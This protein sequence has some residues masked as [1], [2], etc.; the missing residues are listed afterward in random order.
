MKQRPHTPIA[1]ANHISNLVSIVKTQA[2]LPVYPIDVKEVAFE[3]STQMFPNSKI[4]RIEGYDFKGNIEGALAPSPKKDNNWGILYNSTTTPSGRIN[5][6]IAHEFGHFLLH[7]DKF[8]SG[9]QCSSNDLL[10]WDS[11][12]AKIEAEANSF[13][14]N[15]LMPLDDFRKQIKS[16]EVT[17]KCLN[18]LS[19]RYQVSLTAAT[20]RWLEYTN[21]RAMMVVARDGFIDWARSSK[22]L[23]K[24]G[25]F[26]RPKQKIIELPQGS[27]AAKR[28]SS[29]LNIE[30]VEHPVGIWPGQEQVHEM[31]VFTD[32]YNNYSITL[33]KYPKLVSVP[34]VDEEEPMEDT[35]DRFQ[36]RFS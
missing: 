32:Q 5:F 29:F 9:I 17:L 22:N 8:P 31:T 26:Y 19:V 25:I 4:V 36:R 24:T 20:L 10:N 23:F 12:E 18:E 28:D 14:A 11:E 30:G 15:L 33:L 27:L 21:D 7:K 16:K 3:V 13:A 35:V 6:T 34:K 1:W 2:G